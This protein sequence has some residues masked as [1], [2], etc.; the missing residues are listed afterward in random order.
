MGV[1]EINR[2]D[3]NIS[4]EWGYRPGEHHRM[5][6]G[7]ARAGAVET[8]VTRHSSVAIASPSRQANA[9]SRLVDNQSEALCKE[10]DDLGAIGGRERATHVHRENLGIV[11]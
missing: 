9:V 11:D 7:N 4:N 10:L 1:F 2:H 6:G 3:E 5:I 8:T